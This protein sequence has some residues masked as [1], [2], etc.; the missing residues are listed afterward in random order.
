MSGLRITDTNS[1]NDSK[2]RALGLEGND[3]VIVLVALVAA[4][5]LFLALNVGLHL[6]M[7]LAAVLALPVG[8]VPLLWV[9]CLRHNRPDG[10]AADV[11]DDLLNGEGWSLAEQSRS[12]G[13]SQSQP[14]GEESH[15]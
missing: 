15:A 14:S 4:F 11:F 10:Y 8:V 9:L 7:L 1:V 6:R 3:F 12:S 5:G 13:F 2:G